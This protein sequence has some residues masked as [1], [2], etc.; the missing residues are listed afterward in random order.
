MI[1]FQ[2]RNQSELVQNNV[3]EASMDLRQ[4]EA[5]VTKTIMLI[6]LTYIISWMP[7]T[8]FMLIKLLEDHKEAADLTIFG[9]DYS[10]SGVIISITFLL[11]PYMNSSIDPLICILRM[12]DVRRSIM[13]M[14]GWKRKSSEFNLED[15]S[16]VFTNDGF[17]G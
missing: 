4:L 14:L 9:L 2:R 16:N 5:R 17:I 3:Y 10:K 7:S 1:N 8:I 6:I 12:T 11:M 13:K 15:P